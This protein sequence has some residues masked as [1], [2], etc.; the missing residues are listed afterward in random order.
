MMWSGTAAAAPIEVSSSPS[1]A[2]TTLVG[3]SN[4]TDGIEAG[5]VW[6]P[7]IGHEVMISENTSGVTG[8]Y[9][10]LSGGWVNLHVRLPSTFAGGAC[11]PYLVY[12]AADGYL[13]IISALGNCHVMV[14]KLAGNEWKYVPA[15]HAPPASDGDAWP[16]VVYDSG[17]G[18]VLLYGGDFGWC[19]CATPWVFAYHGGAWTRLPDLP[20]N[21]LRYGLTDD[22]AIGKVVDPNDL[23]SAWTLHGGTWSILHFHPPIYFVN[24]YLLGYDPSLHAMVGTGD[25]YSNGCPHTCT[26]IWKTGTEGFLNVTSETTNPG[27]ACYFGPTYDPVLRALVCVGTTTGDLPYETWEFI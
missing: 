12:D 18:L 10:L 27:V 7:G 6:D 26:W 3:T 23:E 20:G 15:R 9:E 13:A 16:S 14:W 8:T 2:W 21:A 1:Y 19:D 24:S 5:P 4:I 22:L 25:T 11:Y 17:D